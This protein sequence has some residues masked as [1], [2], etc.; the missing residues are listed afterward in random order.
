MVCPK[1]GEGELIRIIL[2]MT[3]EKATLCDYCQTLWLIGEDISGSTGHD[4]YSLGD[5]EYM[6]DASD[7]KDHDHTSAKYTHTK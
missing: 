6:I 2:K 3:G 1:C 5:R 4:Y 7:E